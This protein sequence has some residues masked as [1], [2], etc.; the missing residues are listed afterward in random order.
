MSKETK[1][2]IALQGAAG[3]L[4]RKRLP[5]AGLGVFN[6]PS[7]PPPPCPVQVTRHSACHTGCSTSR[8]CRSTSCCAA[9]AQL[10]GCWTSQESEYRNGC[11]GEGGN[12]PP[13][14]SAQR[15]PPI[16]P[17]VTGLLPHLLLPERVGHCPA[18]WQWRSAPRVG[19]G[20]PR[21]PPGRLGGVGGDWGL[22]LRGFFRLK[23]L[24]P[25]LWQRPTHPVYNIVPEKVVKAVMHFL[26]QPVPSLEAAG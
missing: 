5:R 21:K 12:A 20:H 14:L 6:R 24:C 11:L 17:Q 7:L 16:L 23:V 4:G 15:V 8:L 1:R 9:S 2:G 10:G 3:A 18:L 19:P 25:S 13:G 26:Q 22:P